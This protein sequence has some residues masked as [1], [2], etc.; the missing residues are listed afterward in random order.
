MSIA[1]TVGE[2]FFLYKGQRALIAVVNQQN[3][4]VHNNLSPPEIAALINTLQHQMTALMQGMQ[5][6][7]RIA[8]PE[9]NLILPG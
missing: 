7:S 1:V 4:Q 9:K 5:A 2:E 6:E 3:I 8:R